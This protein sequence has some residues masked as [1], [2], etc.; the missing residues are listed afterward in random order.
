MTDRM[1]T[2]LNRAAS[3]T[4]ATASMFNEYREAINSGWVESI[5]APQNSTTMRYG[6]T[7]TGKRKFAA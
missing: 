4:G 5:G 7:E 2:F 3:K 6:I 1:K